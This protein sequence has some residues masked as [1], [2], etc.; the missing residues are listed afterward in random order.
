MTR[1]RSVGTPDTLTISRS[2]GKVVEGHLGTKHQMTSVSPEK[3]TALLKVK[4]H[5]RTSAVLTDAEASELWRL[6][7]RIEQLLEGPQDIE[8]AYDEGRLWILQARPITA[9]SSNEG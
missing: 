2:D 8:W 9:L 4:D 1:G 5:K 6:G 3:G 7:L